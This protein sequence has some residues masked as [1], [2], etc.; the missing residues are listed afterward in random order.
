MRLPVAVAGA[1]V[2]TGAEVAIGAE[3]EAGAKVAAGAGAEVD[4]GAEV[5]AGLALGLFATGAAHAANTPLLVVR[6]AKRR[7][8][9]RGRRFSLI[10]MLLNEYLYP[11]TAGGGRNRK[12]QFTWCGVA[13]FI[14][15]A[16]SILYIMPA[17]PALI[18]GLTATNLGLDTW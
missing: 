8:C 3:V 11:N 16:V 6:A 14:V 7:N 2:A 1:E 18:L 9:R 10:T 12:S 17:S 13:V 5:G 4:A 15:H